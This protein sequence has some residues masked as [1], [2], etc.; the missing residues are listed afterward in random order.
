[1]MERPPRDGARRASAHGAALPPTLATLALALA[2]PAAAIEWEVHANSNDLRSV[3]VAANRVWTL[4]LDGLHAFDPATS[5][6]TRYFREPGGLVSNRTLAATEDAVGSVWIG[7]D[8]GGAA[9][10]SADGRWH[11]AT[12]LQGL[13]SDSVRAVEAFGGGVWVGTKLGLAYFV[14]TEIAGAWPD[15][16]DPSPFASDDIRALE[17]FGTRTWVG[18]TAGV[19]STANGVTWDTV[20]AGLVSTNIVSL[21]HDGTDLWTVTAD[22]L[23]YRG[24]QTGAWTPA[25]APSGVRRLQAAGALYA[26]ASTGVHRWDAAGGTWVSLGGPDARDVDADA[27]GTLWAAAASG[28]WRNAGGGWNRLLSPGPGGNWAH[29]MDLQGSTL[30]FA[31]RFGGTSRYDDARGWRVFLATTFPDTAFRTTSFHFACLVDRAGLKWVGDW[32]GSIARFDDSQATTTFTHFFDDSPDSLDYTI[33]WA[34]AHDPT[35]PRWIGLD[36]RSRGFVDARGLVRIDDDG[37][38]HF[39]EPGTAAMSGKQVRTIAFAPDNAMWVGYADAGVDVFQDRNLQTRVTHIDVA[40]NGLLNADVWSIVFQGSDA[41]VLCSGSAVKLALS[42]TTTQRIAQFFLPAISSQGAVRPMALG[43]GGELWFATTAGLVRRSAS[44]SVEVF[45]TGNSAL[46][47]NDVHSVAY[48]GATGALWV[49]TVLGVN[50]LL[51][52][53]PPSSEEV[54]GLPAVVVFPNPQRLSA[55]GSRFRL[56]DGNGDPLVRTD[57]RIYDLRGRFLDALRTDDFGYFSWTPVDRSGLLLP[58]GVYYLR[59]YGFDAAG[60]PTATGNG[61]IVLRP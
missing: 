29:G 14:G 5:R 16:V 34:A 46:L 9:F 45:T 13:P 18:T 6:F 39:F 4:S 30:Y 60:R 12:A 26:A 42:G 15:G 55:I 52:E 8:G 43:A 35:G 28:L 41:W 17:S 47:S 21:A 2:A 49:G 50:R 25:P 33:G 23:A 1:M 40:P 36:T 48:D 51:P 59:S 24:G 58:S 56:A 32:G 3:R 31:S 10:L 11:P 27:S 54:A 22:G 38:R 20:T 57:V 53:P 44:A 7:T 37:S 61:R 19:Y